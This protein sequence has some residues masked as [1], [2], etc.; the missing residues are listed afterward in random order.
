M[1]RSDLCDASTVIL[2]IGRS[3][4]LSPGVRGHVPAGW[5][6]V[7]HPGIAAPVGEAVPDVRSWLYDWSVNRL[8]NTLLQALL[9]LCLA[10][11]MAAF[12]Q[13]LGR[14]RIDDISRAVVRI[15]ALDRG[16]PASSGSG[17]VVDPRGIIYTNRHVIEDG[18]DYLVELLDDLNEAPVPRFLA[19]LV[20]YSP[21]VDFAV[22]QIDRDAAGERVDTATL[23][24][25][26]VP[27][28]TPEVH[29]GDRVFVFGYP[30][31]G[32]GLLAYT[33]G[34]VT[35]IRNGTLGDMRLP[36]WYQTD[37]QI[38]PGNSGGLAVNAAGEIVGLPTAVLTERRTGGRLGGILSIGAAQA[39]LSI[40]LSEDRAG[41]AGGTT[42]PVI[43]GGRLDFTEPPTFGSV[44]LRS[45]FL[46]DPYAIG[47][48]S[49]GEI[50]VDLG[51]E[52]IGYAAAAPDFRL[53][54][55]GEAPQLRV[56]FVADDGGDTTLLVNQPDGTW[57]CNDDARAGTLDPMVAVDSPIAGQYDIWVGSFDAGSYISGTLYI[58]ELPFDPLSVE[59]GG[60]ASGHDGLDFALDPHFGAVSLRAGFTPDPHT[61]AVLAGGTVDVARLG[62][63]HECLGH[64]ASAPDVRL[65][66]SGDAAELRIF[67]QA[68]D[69]GD[70]TLIVNRPDGSW[71]C[72]DDARAGTLDPMVVIPAPPAGQYDIW[73]GTYRAENMIPGTLKITELPLSP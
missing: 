40:G 65:H 45:G 28:A 58:T 23:G 46:P 22:L 63:G 68:D 52:C 44:S 26:H 50:E 60:A 8:M 39:A 9:A 1:A 11:P 53:N 51:G 13:G 31:L 30:A 12:G 24:L 49:G 21:D 64:A 56:M 25:A 17:T 4:V 61:V 33:E 37:A 38:S 14:D 32:E 47:M 48:V 20:G 36:V 2:S 43:A 54:W 59:T 5:R 57:R 16:T 67:F 3:G 66:W 29:R 34:A 62:L 7:Y 69:G 6:A 35:S 55:S 27:V 73:V 72:N 70:A 71:T 18:E 19:R 41:I 15:V 10:M 42:T